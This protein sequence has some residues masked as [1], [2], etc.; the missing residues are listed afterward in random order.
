LCLGFAEKLL[1]QFSALLGLPVSQDNANRP[2]RSTKRKED[3]VIP[4]RR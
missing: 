2:M 3:T 1:R 4:R